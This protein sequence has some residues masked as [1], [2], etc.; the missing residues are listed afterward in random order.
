[1]KNIRDDYDLIN[2]KAIADY[3]REIKYGLN[4]EELAVLVYRNK[5]MSIEEKIEKY[6]DL[7]NNYPDMEVMYRVNCKP[8]K[9]VKTMIKKEINRLQKLSEELTKEEPDCVW[10]W[11]EYYSDFCFQNMFSSYHE[12]I[13]DIE[14]QMYDIEEFHITKKYFNNLKAEIDAEYIIENKEIIL[15]NITQLGSTYE[16][17]DQIF[18][19]LPTPFKKGDILYNPKK[20]RRGIDDKGVTFVLESLYTWRKDIKVKLALGECDSSDMIA[21]GYYM[22]GYEKM[23]ITLGHMWDYDSFEYFNQELFGRNRL[24]KAISSLLKEQISLELFLYAYDLIGKDV[25]AQKIDW[26]TDEGKKLAGI[27][28]IVK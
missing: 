27:D 10:G 8:Y 17:I 12:T 19:Y 7:I 26:Y 5:R 25:Y 11:N 22:S 18:V 14:F 3:C 23:E 16:D 21:N 15:N 1:M 9:S 24:L 6:N 2:S 4:T 28:K 20:T 13:N